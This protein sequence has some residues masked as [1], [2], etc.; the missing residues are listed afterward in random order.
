MRFEEE[1]FYHIYNRGNNGQ[2]IF[3]ENKNYVYFLGKIEKYL[4]QY[5]DIIAYC[6]MP[7]HFHLLVYCKKMHNSP[8]DS[9][10]PGEYSEQVIKSIAILLRSYTRAIN[11]KYSRSGSLFQ[12]STKSKLLETKDK[13][14][15]F[16]CFH[17]IHQNPVKSKLANRFE[18]WIHS[19]YLEYAGITSTNIC[20]KKVA[21]EYLDIPEEHVSF[22]KQ[23]QAVKL[24]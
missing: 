19:S 16:I 2:K 22:K 6:L 7:N 8:G 13:N 21:Y 23:S 14:Y 12:Q 11:K 9:K 1:K 20:N 5:V 4:G 18:N 17:Y 15:P 10:S 24:T 3:F